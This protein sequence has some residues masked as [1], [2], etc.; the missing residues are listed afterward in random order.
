VPRGRKALKDKALRL[1]LGLCVFALVGLAMAGREP[2][3]AQEE[4]ELA[5]KVQNPVSDLISVPFQHNFNFGVGP[6]DDLQYILNIQP[7]VPFRLPEDWNLIT[8]TILPLVYQPEVAPGVGDEFGLGDIQMSLFFSPAKPGAVI[9]GIG[10]VLQFP[11]ATEEVLGTGKWG[12][13]PTAVGLMIRGPWVVGG[14][15][16][17]LWSFASE[18]NREDVNQMLIQPFL[19]YN[20]P[21]G[22]FLTSSPIIT[23][24]WEADSNDRW[25]VPVGGGVGKVH[26]IGNLP[27]NLQLAGFYNVE[28]PD[29]GPDWS[30]RFQFALL[31]PKR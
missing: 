21:G 2:C 16:N 23:A 27:V 12:I 9:W 15:I 30:L 26:R 31:F 6:G 24:N 8:R 3:L 1:A 11:T 20:F 4:T 19:N 25:T 10:P 14:L 5:K 28:R 7:V 29:N 18:G 22:W 17:N 13:G